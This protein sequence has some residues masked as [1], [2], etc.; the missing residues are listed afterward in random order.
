MAECHNLRQNA[1]S[2]S[3]LVVIEPEPGD[4]RVV[5]IFSNPVK[6]LVSNERVLR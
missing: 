6:A 5:R 4:L 3:H 2:F 1:S